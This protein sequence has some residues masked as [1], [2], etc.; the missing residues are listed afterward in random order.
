[1]IA[2]AVV[3]VIINIIVVVI[4]ALTMLH[5]RRIN[6]I[7]VPKFISNICSRKCCFYFL[8]H[9]FSL[10]D[11]ESMDEKKG[12]IQSIRNLIDCPSANTDA[13]TT[14]FSQILSASLSSNKNFDVIVLM[15][16]TMGY[17]IQYAPA[18][19]V[20][21]IESE[22]S[23]ALEW[24]QAPSPAHRK[25]AG[26]AVLEQLANN[27]PT[28]FYVKCKEFFD[29]IWGP[30]C[31]PKERLRIA[32]AQALSACMHELDK[33][34]YHLQWYCSIYDHVLIGFQARLIGTCSRFTFSC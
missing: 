11:K 8:Q 12:G 18:P 29:L 28:L 19:L 20:D 9:I 26:C 14:S 25:L 27:A 5:I 7:F 24:L 16:H 3:L 32:A 23:R 34:T 30:L 31:D 2:A 15:A 33:R 4:V 21:F 1:M 17:L 22:L 6:V 13:K 10:L